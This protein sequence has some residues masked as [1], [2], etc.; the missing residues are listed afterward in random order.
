M[1]V[2]VLL[3]PTG[4]G[5][6]EVTLVMAQCRCRVMLM[7][8]LPSDLVV[9]RCRYRVMLVTMLLSQDGDGSATQGCTGCAKVVQPPS[10]DHRGVVTS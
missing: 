9:T 4:D 6:A 7:K 1:L 5:A 8:V 10:S 3:S 2:T